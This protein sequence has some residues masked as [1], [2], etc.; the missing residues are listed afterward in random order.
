LAGQGTDVV[1]ALTDYVL[2]ALNVETLSLS[3]GS[4]T[5]A[6]GN[7]ENNTIYGNTGNNTLVGGGGADNL[8]GLGGDDFF[9]FHPG[10]SHGDVVFEFQGNGA[11]AG[12][13]LMFVGYGTL[14]EGATF[15]QLTA[16]DWQINSADGLY[17]ETITMA[18]GVTFDASDLMFM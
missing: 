6:V 1:Y 11:A 10:Q 8:S 18:G 17:H 5:T 7:S 2:T 9:V 4:A 14:A 13:T 15:V 16:T 12:D 3:A